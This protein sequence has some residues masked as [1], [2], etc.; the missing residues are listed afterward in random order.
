MIKIACVGDSI[1]WGYSIIGRSK[2]S[3]PAVLQRLLGDNYIVKNFGFND[4]SARIDSDTP[5]VTKG[6][7]KEALAFR[8]DIVF[9]MLGSND[10]K[11]RNWIPSEYRKGYL[12]IIESFQ[13]L[14]S[15][16]KII[17]LTPPHL[18]LFCGLDIYGL[19]EETM[20]NETIPAICQIAADKNLEVIDINSLLNRRDLFTDGVHPGRRGAAML[21][22]AVAE[23]VGTFRDSDA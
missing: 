6:V 1:T 3:Y 18:Y 11:K 2:Y 10:T 19:S 4:A 17:L 21:A 20:T 9:I 12:T 8:P 16:P 13:N 22:S 23:K 5:Y 7:Y 15:K 14:E